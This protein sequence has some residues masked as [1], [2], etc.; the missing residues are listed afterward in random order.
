MWALFCPKALLFYIYVRLRSRYGFCP[1]SIDIFFQ[2]FDLLFSFLHLFLQ[3]FFFLLLH[4][5]IFF[6]FF[7]FFFSKLLYSYL[8]RRSLGLPGFRGTTSLLEDLSYWEASKECCFPL[9]WKRPLSFL[10]SFS[11][12][13]KREKRRKIKKKS[14]PIEWFVTTH[15]KLM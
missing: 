9:S 2:H 3:D 5:F 6:L 7:F 10:S 11:S 4:L 13:Y 12:L 15:S 14:S 1:Y 8:A